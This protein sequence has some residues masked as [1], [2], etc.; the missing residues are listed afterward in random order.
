VRTGNFYPPIDLDDGELEKPMP[1]VTLPMK[2]NV[3]HF[4]SYWLSLVS[5]TPDYTEWLNDCWVLKRN[6]VFS[7]SPADDIYKDG[8][9]IDFY[10]FIHKL[11]YYSKPNSIFVNDAG[12]SYYICGQELRFEDGRREITSGTFASMGLAIPLAIG[13]SVADSSRQVLAIVGDGSIEPNIQ[14]LKT[15]S[16]LGLD[17]K[18]FVINNGG[19]VSIRHSQDTLCEG[20][21]IDSDQGTS[22]EVLDFE[23]VAKAFNLPFKR[24]V[25]WISLDTQLPE[26]LG[27][28][29]PVLIEVICDPNQ[30][31]L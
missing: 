31:V 14:E 7:E 26:I 5:A 28:E 12:T 15:L 21:H 10:D 2:G 9:P 25:N 8:L 22:G 6:Y 1:G 30:K 11:D 17:V 3:K 27:M 20:R 24:I 19:Y 23:Y 29:G 4:I 16:V 18:V 13:A